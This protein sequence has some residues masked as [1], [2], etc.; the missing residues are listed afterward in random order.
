MHGKYG[1][2]GYHV[3]N[4]ISFLDTFVPLCFQGSMRGPEHPTQITILSLVDLSF[5]LTM[6]LLWSNHQRNREMCWRFLDCFTMGQ[7]FQRLSNIKPSFKYFAGNWAFLQHSFNLSNRVKTTANKSA[8]NKDHFLSV[9]PIAMSL[10][11][12]KWKLKKFEIFIESAIVQQFSL[13][14][15][16]FISFIWQSKVMGYLQSTLHAMNTL[17]RYN[18][19]LSLLRIY[20]CAILKSG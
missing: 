5:W 9:E 15:I 17:A 18:K 16:H 14:H 8:I 19:K 3:I 4:T 20:T 11:A 6:A 10:Q 1:N 2:E 7:T 13:V 12:L